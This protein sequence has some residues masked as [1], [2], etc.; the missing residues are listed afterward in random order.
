MYLICLC[1]LVC[2]CLRY[3]SS[4]P[5]PFIVSFA[6]PISS[7]FRFFLPFYALPFHALSRSS[8]P[9]LA[10]SRPFS[11]FLALS[12]AVSP[13][14][15][16]SF[17]GME[18]LR[19]KN[20]TGKVQFGRLFVWCLLFFCFGQA[21]VRYTCLEISPT[22]LTLVLLLTEDFNLAQIV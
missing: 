2:S 15:F 18:S 3:C 17:S 14:F 6:L 13:S 5:V 4:M 12:V 21:N 10:I 11:F 22:I 9:S 8:S 19:S 1:W 16:L 7:L 20:A